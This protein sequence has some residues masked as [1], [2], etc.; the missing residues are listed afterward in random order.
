M[1][2]DQPDDRFGVVVFYAQ[3]RRYFF[4]QFRAFGRMVAAQPFAY[5][6]QQSPQI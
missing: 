1:V 3:F 6:M 5:V 2:P 4:C